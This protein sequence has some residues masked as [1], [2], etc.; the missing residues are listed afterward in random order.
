MMIVLHKQARTTPAVRAEIAA[1]NETVSS[2]AARFGVT[3]ATVYKWKSRT[4]VHDL[5]AHTK[6]HR[7]ENARVGHGLDASD[8]HAGL[9]PCQGHKKSPVAHRAFYRAHQT[10]RRL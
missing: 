3:P 10:V 5:L 8:H 4:S 1:S 7:P 2:L 9:F 6:S